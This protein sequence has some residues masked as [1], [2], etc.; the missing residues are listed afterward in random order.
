MFEFKLALR[1][2]R[3][4]KVET[5]SL[6]VCIIIAITLIL[7]V[8]IGNHSSQ[9]NKIKL[10]RQVAGNYDAHLITNKKSD[11]KKL[12]ENKSI[13]NITTTKY[14]G[15][16]LNENGLKTSLY[17]F[18]EKY[19]DMFTYKLVEGRFPKNDNEIIMDITAL[20]SNQRK[21][22]LNKNISLS[23]FID[24]ETKG[25]SKT[26]TKKNTYKIVGFITKH[27]QY[28]ETGKL[29]ESAEISSFV[30]N[31]KNPPP[32]QLT[33]YRSLFN[34]KNYNPENSMNLFSKLQKELNIKLNENIHL[35]K[36]IKSG[37]CVNEVLNSAM[38]SYV[39]NHEDNNT[40]SKNY[41]MIISIF[42]IIN[43]FNTIVSKLKSEIG[44]LRII[45]MSN[46]K[47]FKFYAIQTLI[48]SLIGTIIGFICSI[49]YAR[50]AMST[51]VSLSFT[52]VSNF[53]NVDIIMPYK[54]IIK[55]ILIIWFA[56]IISSSVVVLKTLR[57]YPIDIIN[58]TN[59]LRYKARKNKNLVLTLLKNSIFRNK[60]K[61]IMSIII[62]FIS[63]KSVISL[64]S[65]NL[66]YIFDQTLDIE[67]HFAQYSHIIRTP[68]YG[69]KGTKKLDEI[70]LSKIN[71]I[72]EVKDFKVHNYSYGCLRI[73]KKRLH[74]DLS[75]QYLT[76]NESSDIQEYSILIN[77]LYDIDK[78]N[79]FKITG[80]LKELSQSDNGFVNV[81]IANNFYN[82]NSNNKNKHDKGIKDLKLGDTLNV[83]VMDDKQNFQ[84]KTLKCRIVAFINSNYQENNPIYF[85]KH[86]L[87]I[88][89]DMNDF[90]SIVGNNYE[91][92][93]YFNIDKENSP[94]VNKVLDDLK[95]KN[96][97][98]DIL[99]PKLKL[100]N[101]KCR[102]IYK[103]I[104]A[105]LITLAALVNI[106]ITIQ[107]SFKSNL[108]EFSILRALG[109]NTR[110][111]KK[112]IIYEAVI[113]T[114]LGVFLAIIDQ[115]VY[116]I[117]F[118]RDMKESYGPLLKTKPYFPSKE[119]LL[120]LTLLI[121][122]SLIVGYFKSKNI[123]KIEIIQGINEN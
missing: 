4:N 117:N 71:N 100:E 103:K 6:I 98:I 79:E 78:L 116:E 110:K 66:D 24:Y 57:N 63:G 7:G 102:I 119:A 55:Y 40:E 87:R 38:Y 22:V 96:N 92:K 120:F 16:L 58:K 88:C 50:Y 46:K 59:K 121:I 86:S 2:L 26:Y 112:L 90:K 72:D 41:I 15:N 94:K 17:E 70:D 19:L 69:A 32:K 118:I 48:I 54:D 109:I 85:S 122:F 14:L 80:N 106:Y 65:S 67:G 45:G 51:I 104:V 47:V 12:E 52:D 5:L 74:K 9:S 56:I 23:N 34:I 93:V 30:Y 77:G 89:M 29:M 97:F 43:L 20:D 101:L 27:Q 3:K 73:D 39:L 28:Y 76:L 31:P 105:C 21:T 53:N 42:I 13:Y 49:L 91:Q 82:A 36:D 83:K 81:A 68:L 18:N 1:Y 33:E 108:K 8:E 114:F 99:H 95:N 111:L 115:S 62:I 35:K 11:I 37:F 60:F 113:Y 107:L 61:F 123:A 75:P 84:Y 10:A 64:T 44:H 25:E